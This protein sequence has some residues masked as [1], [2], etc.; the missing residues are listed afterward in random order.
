MQLKVYA[1]SLMAFS[2]LHDASA[3]GESTYVEHLP[4]LVPAESIEEAAEAAKRQAFDRWKV[5]EGWYSHQA[6]VMPVTKA[7]FD[8]AFGAHRAGVVD[9]PEED[10]PGQTFQF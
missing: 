1:I 3:S 4:A 7:F 10:E 8:A 9:I 2:P 6:A 5:T